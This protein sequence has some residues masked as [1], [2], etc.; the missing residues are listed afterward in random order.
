MKFGAREVATAT[1]GTLHGSDVTV[2]GMSIDSRADVGGRLFVPIVGERD[3][4]DF[5]GDALAGG[6]AAYLT[7][8]A[9]GEGTAV[10]VDSATA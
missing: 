1:G 4:H 9:P 8:R 7:A 3:G 5:I 6:A 10:A 2:D